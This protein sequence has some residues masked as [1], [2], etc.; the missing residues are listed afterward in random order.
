LDLSEDDIRLEYSGILKGRIPHGNGTLVWKNGS[1]YT[2]NWKNGFRSGFGVMNYR[3]TWNDSI[4]ATFRMTNL[5]DTESTVTHKMVCFTD[6][7]ET[8]KMEKRKEM[9]P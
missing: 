9:G 8:S 4:K 7:T 1:N 2:G 5:M 3:G 6:M